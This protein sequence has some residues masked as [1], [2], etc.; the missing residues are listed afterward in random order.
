MAPAWMDWTLHSWKLKNAQPAAPGLD[1]KGILDRVTRLGGFFA[2]W[3]I[4][5]FGQFFWKIAEVGSPKN[6][7]Y[8]F[9]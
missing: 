4:V 9:W 8:F 2:Y 7:G 6:L 5:N 3:A 1:K